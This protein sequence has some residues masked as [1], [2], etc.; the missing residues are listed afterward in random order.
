MF[1]TSPCLIELGEIET[2]SYCSTQLACLGFNPD[3]PEPNIWTTQNDTG[4]N[5]CWSST[6]TSSDVSYPN[7]RM[8]WTWGNTHSPQQRE[9]LAAQTWGIIWTWNGIRRLK[10]TPP[11]HGHCP[12]SSRTHRPNKREHLLPEHQATLA[13]QIEDAHECL[14]VRQTWVPDL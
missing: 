2:M 12:T 6:Q 14:N 10:T 4:Q 1:D 5:S 8:F 9:T 13:A 7:T 3:E 11:K